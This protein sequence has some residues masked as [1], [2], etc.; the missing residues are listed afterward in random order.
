VD[1]QWVPDTGREEEDVQERPGDKQAI[2]ALKE[3]R[4]SWTEWCL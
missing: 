3:M 4:V 2:A 1:M